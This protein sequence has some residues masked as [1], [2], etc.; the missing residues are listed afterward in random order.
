MRPRTFLAATEAGGGRT[1]RVTLHVEGGV[2]L[3][4][5]VL[6]GAAAVQLGQ[7][8]VDLGVRAMLADAAER[9]AVPPAPACPQPRFVHSLK[10]L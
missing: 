5:R 8:L 9:R 3:G 7:R 4:E 2:L 1:V 6:E 10:V